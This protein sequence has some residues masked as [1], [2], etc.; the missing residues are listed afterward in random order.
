M[1]LEFAKIYPGS[2]QYLY[3]FQ[4][5]LYNLYKYSFVINYNTART[6]GK[7]SAIFM[8]VGNS[9]TVD[10]TAISEGELYKL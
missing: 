2:V 7:G 1:N 3:K 6:T 4:M 5:E 10:C 9:Y 8:H